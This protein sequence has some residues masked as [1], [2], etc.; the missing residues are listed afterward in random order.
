M[1]LLLLLALGAAGVYFLVQGAPT[2]S[3]G[4][5]PSWVNTATLDGKEALVLSPDVAAQIQYAMPFYGQAV[6]TPDGDAGGVITA[7][8]MKLIDESNTSLGA[9]L[10]T[11]ITTFKDPRA[12]FPIDDVAAILAA[13]PPNSAKGLADGSAPP[14]TLSNAILPDVDKL[15][16]TIHLYLYEKAAARALTVPGSGFVLL[17]SA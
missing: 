4:P 14:A 7:K 3:S 5:L 6:V 1:E 8:N 10:G 17:G 16:D 13:F 11:A 2:A 12:L 15:P 9:I